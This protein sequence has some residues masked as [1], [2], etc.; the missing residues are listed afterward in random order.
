VSRTQKATPPELPGLRKTVTSR[1]LQCCAVEV[2]RYLLGSGHSLHCGHHQA[3]PPGQLDAG[4]GRC[5]FIF[6]SKVQDSPAGPTI[7][8]MEPFSRPPPSAV[9]IAGKPVAKTGRPVSAA[10]SWSSGT[11]GGAIAAAAA[12][13][14]RMACSGVKLPSSR[15]SV[16]EHS[17]KCVHLLTLCA[18]KQCAWDRR[19]RGASTS[20]QVAIRA[21]AEYASYSA[22]RFDTRRC[23]SVADEWPLAELG[24][25]H[26]RHAVP[27]K[28]NFSKH[29][30]TDLSSKAT[31]ATLNSMKGVSTP[32]RGCLRAQK[33]ALHCTVRW[34]WGD[35]APQLRALAVLQLRGDPRRTA[36]TATQSSPAK[37]PAVFHAGPHEDMNWFTTGGAGG[38]RAGGRWPGGD[39]MQSRHVRRWQDTRPQRRN[40]LRP[41]ARQ[42]GRERAHAERQECETACDEQHVLRARVLNECGAARR[43]GGRHGRHAVCGRV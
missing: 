22:A 15:R 30:V 17:S 1:C 2:A 26:F 25:M 36:R 13:L 41:A 5:C 21:A 27:R 12:S 11:K 4:T 28:A 38:R 20:E 6:R 16:R 34:S 33:R 14:A 35:C 8:V 3:C 31:V 10:R 40:I 43:Q 29:L 37:R 24:S 23:C 18:C 9:S 32:D 19:P 7:S 42:D 39:Q